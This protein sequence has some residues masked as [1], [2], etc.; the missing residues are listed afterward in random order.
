MDFNMVSCV[1][2]F[3]KKHAIT[4]IAGGLFAILCFIVLNM[5]MKPVS[6]SK[7]CGSK[8]HEMETA[9]KTWK[10]STHGANKFGVSAQCVDCHLPPK[11]KYFTHM[12]VKAYKGAK[13]MFIHHFGGEY[14]LEH[15]RQ[16]VLDKLPNENCMKCHNDL[17]TKP[18]T[19]GARLAHQKVLNPS[20]DLKLK[21]V[22]C[23]E[24]LHERVKKIF[25]AN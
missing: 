22:Q 18:G 7:F 12:A 3:I 5:A 23:H 17:L 14:N 19:S 21:C 9:Y 11:D 6:T 1:C 4:F 8:C 16:N 2:R 10:L 20:S 24:H 13:D 15:A 25:S